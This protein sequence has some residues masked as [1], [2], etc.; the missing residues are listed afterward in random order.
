MRGLLLGV[1]LTI[2]AQLLLVLLLRTLW[3]RRALVSLENWLQHTFGVSVRL[4]D[5]GIGSNGSSRGVNGTASFRSSGSDRFGADG[6]EED[7]WGQNGRMVGSNGRSL[8]RDDSDAS[9]SSSSTSSGEAGCHAYS[10]PLGFLV[11]PGLCKQDQEALTLLGE[12][13]NIVC[14]S[15]GPTDLTLRLSCPVS[16]AHA[17]PCCAVLCVLRQTARR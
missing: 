9:S 12:F 4:S 13:V 6:A 11:L 8:S 1:V 16:G 3:A 5:V 17:V 14:A 15:R 10:M 7:A 2:G